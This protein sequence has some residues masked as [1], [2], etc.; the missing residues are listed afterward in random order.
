MINWGCME[1]NQ[2]TNKHLEKW[3]GPLTAGT[4]DTAFPASHSPCQ[5]SLWEINQSLASSLEGNLPEMKHFATLAESK[6]LDSNTRERIN[7]IL[8][9]VSQL[10]H[11]GRD[12][13]I[14]FKI[15]LLQMRKKTFLNL[16]P[17]NKHSTVSSSVT[18][19]SHSLLEKFKEQAVC[20]INVSCVSITSN[21]LLRHW[22]NSLPPLLCFPLSSTHA[23]V[24]TQWMLW[25]A[26]SSSQPQPAFP[27]EQVPFCTLSSTLQGWWTR[28]PWLLYAEKKKI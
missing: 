19:E 3:F 13:T 4:G 16:F 11:H 14:Q 26:F 21:L 27:S 25:D 10:K 23:K 12:Q 15:K 1:S 24:M 20:D 9:S 28:S 8:S 6:E 22:R 2:S 18:K 5:S 17:Q 7:F